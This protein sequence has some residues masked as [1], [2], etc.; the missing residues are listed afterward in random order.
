MC[1]GKIG[2]FRGFKIVNN[3]LKV[4]LIEIDG[5]V[6]EINVPVPNNI[7]KGD[8]IMVY[9]SYDIPYDFNYIHIN[10]NLDRFINILKMIAL[11]I[12]FSL[13][14]IVGYTNKL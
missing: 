10:L 9:N 2:T 7:K 1:Y 4:P 6:R 13:G 14:G 8:R 11:K 5:V 12:R 3:N